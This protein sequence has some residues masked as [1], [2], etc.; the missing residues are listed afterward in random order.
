MFHDDHLQGHRFLHVNRM[1]HVHWIRL[2][3]MNCDWLGNVHDVDVLVGWAL[4]LYLNRVRHRSFNWIGGLFFYVDRNFFLHHY[5]D[6]LLNVHRIGN[7]DRNGDIL[8]H[9]NWVGYLLGDMADADDLLLL[10]PSVLV[11][12]MLILLTQMLVMLVLFLL[13][14]IIVG[15]VLFLLI[16]IV[17]ELHLLLVVRLLLVLLLVVLLLLNIMILN[18]L[19]GL[20]LIL[21]LMLKVPILMVINSM[22]HWRT[23]L[24]RFPLELLLNLLVVLLRFVQ[25]LIRLGPFLL[26]G[27]VFL[28]IEL[29]LL[30]H[31][32]II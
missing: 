26:V 28:I 2:I 1:L 22:M 10:I 32:I 11:L 24:L 9:M 15:L 18:G 19:C 6:G 5:W 20:V 12:L 14:L 7:V 23:F 31:V 8:L 30:K 4:D 16:L 17:L 29:L 13:L 25:L 21:M 3:D 27:L